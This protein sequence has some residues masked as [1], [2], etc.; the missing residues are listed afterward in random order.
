MLRLILLLLLLLM[1]QLVA[2]GMVVVV[3]A[4]CFELKNTGN[5]AGGRVVVVFR[6]ASS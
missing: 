6:V 5:V 4:V 2:V 1:L 3:V